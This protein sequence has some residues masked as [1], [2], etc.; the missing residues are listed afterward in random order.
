MEEFSALY[1]IDR[2]GGLPKLIFTFPRV[3]G[4][5][6]VV[7]TEDDKRLILGVVH[8]GTGDELDEITLANGSRRALPLGQGAHMPAISP[9]GDKLAFATPTAVTHIW[10]KDLRH[11]ESPPV[12]FITSTM[13]D[14]AAQYSPDGKHIALES[15]RTG[16]MEV[17]MCDPDG[18]HLVQISNFRHEAT[19]TPR[20]SP[21]S[22]KIVFDSRKS[23]RP[24][25]YVADIG[26]RI[27]RK[28]TTNILDISVPSWSHD[29]QW[30]YF[31]AN[32]GRNIYRCPATG[33][34]AELLAAMGPEESGLVP[35]E[36]FDGKTVYFAQWGPNLILYQLSLVH[37]GP[38]SAVEGMPAR[39]SPFR[40]TVAPQGIYFSPVGAGNTVQFFDFGTRKVS[41][42]LETDSSLSNGLSVSPDGR[43]LLFS[44]GEQDNCDIVLVE[45]FR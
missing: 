38:K 43:W 28:L 1:A 2:S 21:D 24:E 40:W 17:W 22:Q 14:R 42:V 31:Q 34:A 32:D 16:F 13:E 19:G 25:I 36:S 5:L 30:I 45:N 4:P 20:W 11:P 3:P 37:P 15:T 23:G 9:K 35:Q 29:G 12:K 6:G 26:E 39:M 8:W 41:K 33:G 10:R 7:W 27:P 18:S 44:K